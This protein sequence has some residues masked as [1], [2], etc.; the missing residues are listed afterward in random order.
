[1]CLEFC[2]SQTPIFAMFRVENTKSGKIILHG[3]QRETTC[4][5]QVVVR[6]GEF[7]RSFF[8]GSGANET[9]AEAKG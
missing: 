1:M 7:R 2:P 6:A 5:P 9:A 8:E 3:L 4:L